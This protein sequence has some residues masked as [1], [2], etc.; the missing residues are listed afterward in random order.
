MSEIVVPQFVITDSTNLIPFILGQM[1][2]HSFFHL[3][4]AQRFGMPQ[5][6]HILK[7]L[8][9]IGKNIALCFLVRVTTLGEN[10][11]FLFYKQPGSTAIF[12]EQLEIGDDP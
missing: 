8:E 9:R 10:A 3:D 1:L 5:H 7:P 4:D 12:I 2:P 11:V 6:L